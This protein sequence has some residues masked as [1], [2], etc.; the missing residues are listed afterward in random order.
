MIYCGARGVFV[1]LRTGR[2]FIPLWT[3]HERTALIAYVAPSVF[4]Y[5]LEHHLSVFAEAVPGTCVR[6]KREENE[7]PRDTD[8]LHHDDGPWVPSRYETCH[9]PVV[10]S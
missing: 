3:V 7:H 5:K 6:A 10:L 1:R 9:R 2:R 4:A 8:R